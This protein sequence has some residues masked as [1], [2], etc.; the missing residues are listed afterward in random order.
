MSGLLD[1]V[2][3]RATLGGVTLYS[4]DLTVAKIWTLVALL[5]GV[6]VPRLLLLWLIG[7]IYHGVYGFSQ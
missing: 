2:K 6:D 5:V 7:L 3:L 1:S 4:A